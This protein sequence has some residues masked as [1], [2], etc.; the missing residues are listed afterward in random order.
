ME[1]VNITP[2]Q[3]VAKML[4]HDRFSEWMGLKIDSVD[5]G[6]CKLHYVVKEEML[7][8]FGIIHGGA[9]FAASDSAFA[10]ACNTY[11]HLTV[12]LDVSISFT[13]SASV[14]EL[15]S[16]EAKEIHL[17]NKTGVYEIRTTNEKGEL[18][19]IFKG[20][21]YRTSKLIEPLPEE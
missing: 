21:A 4:A 15:L 7:N 2:Q 10:F 20:T 3:A 5:A 19:S 8:G 16:V 6:Y 1:K 18:L 11:G 13:R 17:G 9:L 12:A 14:G